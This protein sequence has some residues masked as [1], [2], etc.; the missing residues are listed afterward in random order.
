MTR[1]WSRALARKRQSGQPSQTPP[2]AGR[3][4]SVC[5][6]L[7]AVE[8]RTVTSAVALEAPSG[9]PPAQ[10][11]VWARPADSL[12][13]ADRG[14]DAAAAPDVRFQDIPPS[15]PP[16]PTAADAAPLTAADVRATDL[17]VQTTALPAA[18]VTAA[19]G[20]RP[21]AEMDS[22]AQPARTE[23]GTP[24]DGSKARRAGDPDGVS[25]SGAEPGSARRDR[26]A[27]RPESPAAPGSPAAA[28]A[29][30]A[31]GDTIGARPAAPTGKVA[32]GRAGVRPDAPDLAGSETNRAGRPTEVS[33]LRPDH[34]LPADPSDGLLLQRFVAD[35]DQAAFAALVQRHGSLVLGVCRQV[36]GDWGAAQDA[37]QN[38]FLVLARKAGLLD[39]HSPLG[40]WLYKVAYRLALRSRATTARQRLTEQEAGAAGCGGAARA[41]ADQP[42]EDVEQQ[43]L[44]QVLREELQRLPEEYRAPLMLCYLDGRTHA[45]AAREIGLPRGSMAK[46]IG[47]G[48]EYLRERLLVRGFML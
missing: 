45:D 15:Q 20:E 4:P 9:L 23:A 11:V 21:L 38:T 27:A 29:S 8:D 13:G 22:A 12:P 41:A 6:R 42:G 3:R 28:P 39:R 30:H 5:L 31:T 10:E 44:R 47:E 24:A 2:P 17:P 33:A 16:A 34:R 32:S 26:P 1:P 40:G 25:P 7:E 36:L 35:R 37:F 48:L 19:P 46:R 14:T 43:E 18:H